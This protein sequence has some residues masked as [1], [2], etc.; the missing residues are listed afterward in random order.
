V[1]LSVQV[2]PTLIG[3]VVTKIGA[4]VYDGSIRTQLNRI[5][6]ILQKG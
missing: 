3:G 6:S 2:E 1:V 5:E 4:M